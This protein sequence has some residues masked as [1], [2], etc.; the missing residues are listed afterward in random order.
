MM[1]T[2]YGSG[3]KDNEQPE[4]L[5][6]DLSSFI[7]FGGQRTMT[8]FRKTGLTG[9]GDKSMVQ[10]VEENCPP[11]RGFLEKQSPAFPYPYQRRFCELIDR[12]FRYYLIKNDKQELKGV[13]N[14]DLYSCRVED[15]KDNQGFYI[16]ILNSKKDFFFRFNSS[17][18]SDEN[19]KEVAIWIMTIRKH[20]SNSAGNKTEMLAPKTEKFWNFEQISCQ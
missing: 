8:V 20:I 16:K 18:K 1:Q 13:I 3:N 2:L 14:F 7:D 15:Y 12:E 4:D 9:L 6:E 5:R 11:K 19:K 10:Q 17:D